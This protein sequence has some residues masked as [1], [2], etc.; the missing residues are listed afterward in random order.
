MYQQGPIMS[1]PQYICDV[2]GRK[3]PVSQMVGKCSKCGCYVCSTCG[4]MKNDRIYCAKHVPACFIATAAYGTSMCA[5]I[6]ILREFRNEKLITNHVGRSLVNLYY[7]LSP[8][9]ANVISRNNYMRSLVRANLSPIVKFFN[10]KK[11]KSY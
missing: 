5:E 2:C 10:Q 6:D 7:T 9:I 4:K 8:P 11:W 3:K 1:E